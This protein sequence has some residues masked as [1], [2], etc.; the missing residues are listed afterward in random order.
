[1]SSL[2]EIDGVAFA[3]VDAPAHQAPS[4]W[5]YALATWQPMPISEQPTEKYSSTMLVHAPSRL[6]AS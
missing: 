6:Y 4:V 3:T 1:M 5:R 2:A